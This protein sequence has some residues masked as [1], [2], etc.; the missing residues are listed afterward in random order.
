MF[1]LFRFAGVAS[2]FSHP[3]S[4]LSSITRTVTKRNTNLAVGCGFH[5]SRPRTAIP[6]LVLIVL[7]P[8]LRLAAFFAGRN[9]RKWWRA[10]PKEKRAYYWSRIKEKKWN[11]AGI[12][13][14]D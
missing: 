10:L 2:R 12:H 5:T 7:R 1:G 14:L 11:I 13:F 6:P 8:V 4:R 3:V 9:F